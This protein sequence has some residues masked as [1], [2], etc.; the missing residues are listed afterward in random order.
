MVD[1]PVTN[2]KEEPVLRASHQGKLTIA[3]F[4]IGC[5]VLDTTDKERVL[6]RQGILKALGRNEKPTR[7]KEQVDNL[8]N[9]LRA[10]NL[11]PFISNELIES[12]K[13]I[14]FVTQIGKKAI[15][16]R[17][18]IL[19]DICYVFIDAHKA[20]ALKSQQ[21]HIAERCELLVRGFA[22]V[23]LRA[24]VDEATGFQEI[25]PKDDLQRYLDAFLLKE[26]AKWAKRFPDEFFKLLF[27]MMGWT[28]NELS[29]KRTP[30]IGKM[31]NNLVYER[32]APLVLEELRVKNPPNDKGQR[33]V[34]HHQF[35]TPEIGHPKLQEHIFALIALL[36]ASGLDRVKFEDMVNVALPR[37]GHTIPIQFLDS[38]KP[39]PVPIAEFNQNIKGVLSVSLPRKDKSEG[40]K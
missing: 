27:E 26:H 37:H 17:P 33:K 9:F 7:V 16:F 29:T 30:Y 31:I 25:R 14:H 6:S 12:T 20:G 40:N 24:L 36:K 15:G 34:K 2:P 10:A 4:E 22:S 39:R 3:G 35:L 18:D 21:V 38:D 23:G 13:P 8:P 1:N 11:K 28:W 5:Y 19:S 32:L